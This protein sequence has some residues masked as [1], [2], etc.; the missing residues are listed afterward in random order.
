MTSEVFANITWLATVSGQAVF[1]DELVGGMFLAFLLD[2]KEKCEERNLMSLFFYIGLAHFISKTMEDTRKAGRR[3]NVETFLVRII[4]RVFP[5]ILH[6]VRIVEFPHGLRPH[7]LR[8][9]LHDQ[10][11]SCGERLVDSRQGK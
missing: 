4:T 6:L 2:T 9:L 1:L 10:A 7:L 8:H 3:N 5:Y 11:E